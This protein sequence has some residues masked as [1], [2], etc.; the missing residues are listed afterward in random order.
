MCG[1]VQQWRL[2]RNRRP[3]VRLRAA[4]AEAALELR[5]DAEVA[6]ASSCALTPKW[7]V[8]FMRPETL[9]GPPLQQE[10][11]W[12]PSSLVMLTDCSC[13]CCEGGFGG[14]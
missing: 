1:V 6:R 10:S 9:P 12:R 2:V 3:A 4:A 8:P 13:P 5:V 7:R 14:K 11:T